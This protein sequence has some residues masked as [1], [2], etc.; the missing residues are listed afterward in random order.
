MESGI[1]E[2]NCSKDIKVQGIIGP[3]A[4]LEKKGPLCS[5][6]VVGQGNTSAWKMHFAQLLQAPHD[7]ADAI[8]KDRFPVP[9]LV[10]CDQHGSQVGN[11]S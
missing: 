1:F 4:S 11:S 9:R 2:I 5:D 3:C 7:D 6:T 10:I 8:V